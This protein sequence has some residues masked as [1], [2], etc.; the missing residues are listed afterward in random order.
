MGR[1]VV[2]VDGSQDSRQALAWAAE[3]AQL[4]SATLETV[5]A[6]HVPAGWYGLGDGSSTILTVPVAIDELEAHAN[7]V[8]ETT[9]REVLG[10]DPQVEIK[11]TVVMG[12]P[13]D[14]LIEASSSADVLVVGS[15]GHGNLGSV[16]LG[17]V[18]MHCVHHAH[19]PVVVIP[20]AKR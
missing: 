9:L 4:R 18:G 5:C 3:E 7:D 10:A 14:V 2:G 19:C 15:R 16:L 11:R 20:P 13:A 12:Q 6:Y 8:L 1:I 17:S